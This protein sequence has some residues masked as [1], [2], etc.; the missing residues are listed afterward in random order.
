MKKF[1][2]MLILFFSA[3]ATEI[4]FTVQQ[5][6]GVTLSGVEFTTSMKEADYGLFYG[7]L[8]SGL[9]EMGLNPE[10]K[11]EV[12]GVYSYPEEMENMW[13][14]E[15]SFFAGVPLPP[16]SILPENFVNWEISPSTY[17][18]FAFQGA[19]QK[20][21][22]AYGYIYGKWM[23]TSGYEYDYGKVE[24]EYYGPQYNEENPDESVI[25]IYIPVLQ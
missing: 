15:F 8:E 25:Y 13:T 23:K 5:F 6:P 22:K 7:D 12:Y 18:V 21:G 17:A 2:P 11:N 9:I 3:C 19:P 20:I 10:E 16:D 14:D 24:F 1:I 4:P